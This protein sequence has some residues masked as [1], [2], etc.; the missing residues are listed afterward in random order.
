MRL[1]PYLDTT[2]RHDLE[3]EQEAAWLVETWRASPYYAMQQASRVVQERRRQRYEMTGKPASDDTG[4][5]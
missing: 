1:T 3:V 2:D 4:D 5:A